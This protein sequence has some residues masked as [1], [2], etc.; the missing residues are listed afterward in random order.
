MNSSCAVIASKDNNTQP[1]AQ[2]LSFACEH[3]VDFYA[4]LLRVGAEMRKENEDM[5]LCTKARK[6]IFLES[7]TLILDELQKIS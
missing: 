2:L 4:R 3:R 6:L 5:A 7:K 1:T